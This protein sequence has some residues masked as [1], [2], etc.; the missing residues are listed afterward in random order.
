MSKTLAFDVYGTLI[1][2]H[3][4]LT[5]LQDMVADKALLF[6]NTWRNKQL[7]YSFR[8]GLMQRYQN[9]SVCTSQALDF[10]ADYLK[11]SLTQQQKHTLLKAYQTLPSFSDVEPALKTL[12][13]T[14]QLYAFSNG[15]AEAVDTLLNSAGLKHHFID[16]ISTDEI[17][18][19]KPN[20]A[21]YQHLLTRAGSTPMNTWLIS[22]NP[23]D[24]IGALDS[25]LNAAWVKRTTHAVFDPWELTPTAEIEHLTE[26]ANKLIE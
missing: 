23:F 10:T 21:C 16:I 6:S 18:T 15:S 1:N 13:K 12:G 8:R 3:G 22:S 11:V 17:Q 26:L 20:P 24:V 25:Q 7:E 9:F 4:V 2:T 19:F 14:H 5:L